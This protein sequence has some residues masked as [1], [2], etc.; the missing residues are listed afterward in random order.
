MIS[1]GLKDFLS[2]K[3]ANVVPLGALKISKNIKKY[4]KIK[5]LYVG[6]L[7]NRNIHETVEA[8][9]KFCHDYPND[10]SY[11]IIGF[12]SEKDEKILNHSIEK[13]DMSKYVKFIGRIPIDS[14]KSYFDNSNVGVAYIPMT[15]YYDNQPPTK[16]FEYS[17]S[18][19]ITIA[20]KTKI[21][22]E[23]ITKSNGLLCYDNSNSFYKTLIC[24]R[25][26]ISYFKYENI[27]ES[28]S[29]YEWSRIINSKLKPIIKNIINE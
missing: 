6:T 17:M 24:L 11:N 4:Q 26:K 27:V 2:L 20:T 3:S 13:L 25:E 23:L 12:G 8:V 28:H 22:I 1:N 10:I 7:E 18:G 15:N 21:N 16:I 9:A 5:L 19:L 29:E 14:L